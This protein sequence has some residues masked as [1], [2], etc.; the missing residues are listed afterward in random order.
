MKYET[1]CKADFGPG[2]RQR[3]R[4]KKQEITVQIG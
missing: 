2:I 1:I 4:H 3:K